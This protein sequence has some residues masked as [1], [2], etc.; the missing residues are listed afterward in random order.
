MTTLYSHIPETP[1]VYLMKNRSGELLYIG[2]AGNLKRRVS[3]YFLRP[4][5]SRIQKL[6]STIAKIDFKKTDTALEALILESALIKKYQPPYNIREKDDRSFLY[7]AITKDAFPRFLLV[8]G[9]EKDTLKYR[10]MYGPFTAA[11]Q[12]REALKILRRVFPYSIH[13]EDDMK[14]P[15]F[16]YQIGLCPGTCIH[17]IQR[18]EYQKTIQNLILFFEGGKKKIIKNF[19]DGMKLASRSLEFEKAADLKRRIFALQH[20]QDIA[21]IGNS[22]LLTEHGKSVIPKLRIEGYDISNISGTSA[23]GSMV[24]FTGG[25]PDK[26][27][28]RKFR[29][30]NFKEPNDVGMLKEM[31]SR[32]FSRR[33]HQGGLA[34]PDLILIDG[35]KPQVNAARSILEST[36]LK[37][38]IVGIAKGPTRK[39][40]EFH[41]AIPYRLDPKILIRVRD[42]AH[43]FAVSYH[44][45]VRSRAFFSDSV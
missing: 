28:Y 3:S 36:G 39:K 22:D 30:Q 29:I 5:D 35:G 12:I 38:P 34:L 18:A 45:R 32:R 27:E 14:R 21:L 44:K 26:K 19:T 4:H 42:E 31:L 1:G 41:G 33:P 7:V 23:V 15:C 11:G 20:I 9:K 17:A 16:D 8:R 10:R 24:V 6:V 25:G 13:P 43:R 37:I 40:N 2:K